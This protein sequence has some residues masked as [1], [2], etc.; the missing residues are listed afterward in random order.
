MGSIDDLDS[1]ALS[2]ERLGTTFA[3]AIAKNSGHFAGEHDVGGSHDAVGQGGGNRG[4]RTC[5]W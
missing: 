3:V 4:C 5:S 1:A 2:T